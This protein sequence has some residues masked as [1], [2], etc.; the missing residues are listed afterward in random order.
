MGSVLILQ[1]AGWRFKRL[2]GAAHVPGDGRV[3]GNAATDAAAS[4]D[5][6]KGEKLYVTGITVDRAT[7]SIVI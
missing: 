6:V 2:P 1:K 3:A 4:R 5:I 7:D